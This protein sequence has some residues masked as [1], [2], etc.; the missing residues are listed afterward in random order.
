MLDF[1]S[2]T[3]FNTLVSRF[4]KLVKTGLNCW[5]PLVKDERYFNP[6]GEEHALN[7]PK[8]WDALGLSFED[9]DGL[10][11]Q[12]GMW[13]RKGN[14]GGWKGVLKTWGIPDLLLVSYG[15]VPATG[16]HITWINPVVKTECHGGADPA[17]I[18]MYYLGKAK[19]RLETTRRAMERIGTLVHTEEAAAVAAEEQEEEAA[20]AGGQE[21]EEYDEDPE[22][23]LP[24]SPM[25]VLKHC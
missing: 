5:F 6:P 24:A 22:I 7:V 14:G 25:E 2:R 18:Q 11:E 15:R 16:S 21:E 12:P 8:I 17:E 10:T 23:E 4:Q 1:T 9:F 3:N 13:A 20:A 19:F